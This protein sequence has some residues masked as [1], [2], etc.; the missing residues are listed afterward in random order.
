MVKNYLRQNM[1]KSL[2]WRNGEALVLLE[3]VG[4][5]RTFYMSWTKY[6]EENIFLSVIICKHCSHKIIS[7]WVETILIFLNFIKASRVKYFIPT[8]SFSKSQHG[9]LYP[10]MQDH[11]F[12]KIFLHNFL[13]ELM[14]MFIFDNTLAHLGLRNV[15]CSWIRED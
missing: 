15:T 2:K 12:F 1:S 5:D 7:C 6:V 9:Y 10:L 11:L 13:I 14:R 8:Y 3:E 4:E